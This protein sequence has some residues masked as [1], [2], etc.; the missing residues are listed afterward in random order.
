M[1]ITIRWHDG[2]LIPH[3]LDG[4]DSSVGEIECGNV[5]GPVMPRVCTSSSTRR[6]DTS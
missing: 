5:A 2:Y 6:V 3:S 1:K 4:D